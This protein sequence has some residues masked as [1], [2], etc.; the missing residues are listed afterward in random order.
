MVSK[1]ARLSGT[2]SDPHQSSR[3]GGLRDRVYSL[4]ETLSVTLTSQERLGRFMRIFFKLMRVYLQRYPSVA[5]AWSRR[6]GGTYDGSEASLR[7][8]AKD[9]IAFALRPDS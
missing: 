8:L 5:R 2:P 4:G 7:S 6:V 1:I 9:V 3:R